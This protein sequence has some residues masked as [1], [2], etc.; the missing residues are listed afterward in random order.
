MTGWNT[1]S[2]MW[3]YEMEASLLTI[4]I[5]IIFSKFTDIYRVSVINPRVRFLLFSTSLTYTV[6]KQWAIE[7]ELGVFRKIIE[8]ATDAVEDHLLDAV[9]AEAL[10]AVVEVDR[11]SLATRFMMLPSKRIVSR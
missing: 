4:S 10:D 8:A 6:N 7:D 9:E 3:Y 5:I 2:K 1:K 11:K